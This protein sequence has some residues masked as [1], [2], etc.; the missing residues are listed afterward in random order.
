MKVGA[1]KVVYPER[2]AGFR[3]AHI[4]LS[5]D[6]LD[7]FEISD[8]VSMVEM[9]PKKEWVGKSLKQLN[10]RG[11]YRINV[12]AIKEKNDVNVIVD[13]DEPLKAECPLIITVHKK[14][15]KKIR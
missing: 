12:I 5:S 14:D 4:L 10:L 9:F 13:P 2:E 6:F 15:L 3:L 1:D 8:N 11:N 7:Y